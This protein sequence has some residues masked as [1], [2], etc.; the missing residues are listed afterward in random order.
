MSLV[1]MRKPSSAFDLPYFSMM[2]MQ[3]SAIFGEF[4]KGF[5]TCV[6]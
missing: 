6:E 2:S 1:A 3:T 4:A 5:V